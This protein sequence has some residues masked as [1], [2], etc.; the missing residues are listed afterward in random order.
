[1]AAI[2]GLENREVIR[3]K[4]KV[5]KV[6]FTPAHCCKSKTLKI[7]II[8][9][10]WCFISTFP[11]GKEATNGKRTTTPTLTQFHSSDF[12]YPTIKNMDKGHD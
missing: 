4:V 3:I 11:I 8:V 5:L 9:V 6:I 10:C 7:S 2:F 12:R 1:M